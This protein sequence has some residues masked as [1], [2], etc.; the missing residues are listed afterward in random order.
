[1]FMYIIVYRK[2]HISNGQFISS[3]NNYKRLPNLKFNSRQ[4]AIMYIIKNF[5]ETDNIN[6][7][8]SVVEFSNFI[9]YQQTLSFEELSFLSD[10]YYRSLWKK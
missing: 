1:M 5:K 2:G 9:K 10:P 8:L 4:S 3:S 6:C 7:E